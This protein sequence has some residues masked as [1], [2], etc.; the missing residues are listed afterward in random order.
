MECERERHL[1]AARRMHP[2][3]SVHPCHSRSKSSPAE[4]EKPQ[5]RSGRVRRAGRRE[6][7]ESA[8]FRL[9]F[10]VPPRLTEQTFGDRRDGHLLG[11]PVDANLASGRGGRGAALPWSDSG[12][13]MCRG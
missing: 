1:T 12:T 8:S 6:E 7:G 5:R 4:Q 13:G 2:G 10:H 9:S 3:S 11:R